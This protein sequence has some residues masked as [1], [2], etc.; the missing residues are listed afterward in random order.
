MLN[1]R[2]TTALRVTGIGPLGDRDRLNVREAFF[3]FP[4]TQG[5][6]NGRAGGRPSKKEERETYLAIIVFQN[7]TWQRPPG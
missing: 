1:G 6:Q 2:L 5:R 4:S 3:W 7:R